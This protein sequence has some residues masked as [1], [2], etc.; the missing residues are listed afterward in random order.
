[1][2]DEASAIRREIALKWRNDRRQHAANTRAFE[3][4][5]RRQAVVGFH[6]GWSSEKVLLNYQH[7]H[8]SGN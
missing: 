3:S 4:W 5:L 8:G 7:E 1:M 6:E 2:L